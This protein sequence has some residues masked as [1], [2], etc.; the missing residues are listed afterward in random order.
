MSYPP[1]VR[2]KGTFPVAPGFTVDNSK[3]PP[4]MDSSPGISSRSFS[5]GMHYFLGAAGG[6]FGAVLDGAT[7]RGCTYE[8]DVNPFSKTCLVLMRASVL[9]SSAIRVPFNW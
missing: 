2:L 9:A 1:L 6:G 3:L 4:T 8:E 5:L 7:T